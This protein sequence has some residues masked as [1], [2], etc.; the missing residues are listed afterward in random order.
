M[1][2]MVFTDGKFL[3]GTSSSPTDLSDHVRSMTIN[4]KAEIQDRTAMSSSARR[5]IPGLK[6]WD[7]SV[8]FNQ[9][10][11]ASKVDAT[12]WP[13]IGSTAKYCQF[14]PNSSASTAVN[15]RYVGHFVVESYSPVAGS[16]GDLLTV[17]VAL[18]GDGLLHRYTS[19]T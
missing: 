2:V 17:T 7:A 15:P 16:V 19:A 4:Y 8:E 12:F 14:R 3:I 13:L 1:A 11:A 9:D 6:D 5:R 10:F 18:T